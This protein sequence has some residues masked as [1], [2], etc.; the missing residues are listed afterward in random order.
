M[1]DYSNAEIEAYIATGDP[2]DKAGAYAIQ[3]RDFRPVVKLTDCFAGVMGLPLCHLTRA[4]RKFG[5]IGN[6]NIAHVCQDFLDY[7][8]GVYAGILQLHQ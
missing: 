6:G 4:L 5:V 8:C 1:R 3:H 2:M 7:E